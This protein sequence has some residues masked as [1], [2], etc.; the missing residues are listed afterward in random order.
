MKQ[1]KLCHSSTELQLS[2]IVP[3]FVYSWM[4]KSGTGRFRQLKKL[5]KPIQDGIKKYL[6][7]E[8]C[9]K[10][11][12]QKEKWFKENLFES[13]LNA[14][15]TQFTNNPALFYFA[16]SVLWRV[17]IYFKDDGNQYYFK[18]ELD[19]AE[20][21]WR[22]FLLK[23]VP[24]KLF[25]NIH[26]IFIPEEFDI[27]SNVKNLYSYFHRTVDLEIVESDQKSFVYAKFSRFILIG[28]IF[29]ITESDFIGTNLNLIEALIPSTQ[30]IK[31]SDVV[32]FMLSRVTRIK[33]YEDLSPNQQ[34]Q[35]DNYYKEKLDRIKNSDY[36]NV[37]KK[38]TK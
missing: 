3:K 26:F 11:I 35:N 31:D 1:C 21:E 32:D 9:E 19:L 8:E 15:K 7:C 33:S 16:I 20:K 10:K 12:A 27:R 25:Q 24:L 5:N 23:G 14:P 2:H 38:D 29:G 37:L 18:K 13:Y 4:K 22:A 34:Q 28:E 6:L 30:E 36:W 17:L